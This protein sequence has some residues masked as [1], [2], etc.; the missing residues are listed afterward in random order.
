MNAKQNPGPHSLL[1]VGLHKDQSSSVNNFDSDKRPA[2]YVTDSLGQVVFKLISK[3]RKKKIVIKVKDPEIDLD[4]LE[5]FLFE[6]L[7]E[8]VER[9]GC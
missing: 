1:H 8:R 6:K 2:L 7:R 4:L 9:G 3:R 5:Q